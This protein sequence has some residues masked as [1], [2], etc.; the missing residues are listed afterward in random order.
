MATLVTGGTGFV[1]ANIVK[2]LAGAGHQV[3]CLDLN[4][5]DRLIQD[6][7]GEAYS[8]VSFV[9]GDILDRAVVEQ[10]RDNRSIDK[11]VHAAVF[12][13]NRIELE[14]QRSKDIV[15]INIAGTAN[16]LELARICQVQRFLYVSSGAVYG[17]AQPAD[18]TLNENDQPAPLNLYGITKYA[19]E[20]LTRR[21]GELH[22]LSAASV[23]L[24]TPYGPME[25]VTG[26]R[27]VMSVCYQW[28]GQAL[29][30]ETIH[31]GDLS[32]GRDYTY[33]ADIASGIRSVLD[34]PVLPHDLY[35]ITA[36]MW[37]S[38]K[39]IL[40]QLRELCPATQVVAANTQEVQPRFLEPSRG[41]LSGHRLRQDLGWV[42]RYDLATGLADYLQWRRDTPFL[43]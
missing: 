18:Q 7:L 26:H 14:T 24:S 3:I 19:S 4:G 8:Q 5:P 6:F 27:A 38:F 12:T 29:R 42:P 31:V 1:G 28:T 39:D 30:G 34:T 20:L 41:P 36:G 2:E 16:L 25:R 21:Y 37:I 15:D 22:Q 9:Q 23:R 35:N 11:V 40:A 13:V 43:D 10:L 33:V 17:A 32:Q